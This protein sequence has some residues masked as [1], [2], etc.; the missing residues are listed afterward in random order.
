MSNLYIHIGHYKTGTT[1]LQ[2]FLAQNFEALNSLGINYIRDYRENAKHSLLAFSVLDDLNVD[3]LMY[4]YKSHDSYKDLW[5][6]LLIQIS[7]NTDIQN[8]LISSEEFIRISE[9]DGAVERLKTI[10]EMATKY[11]VSI[12]PIVYLREP[13]KH[14]ESWFNQLTK[15]NIYNPTVDYEISSFHK[16]LNIID[17]IHFDYKVALEPW[18]D[19]FGIENVVFKKYYGSSK[20]T[21]YIY[22]DFLSIF[23]CEL[24]DSF[25]IP[26]GNV[27]PRIDD[28]VMYLMGT[29]ARKGYHKA[30]IN[31]LLNRWNQFKPLSHSDKR[32][33]REMI[34]NARQSSQWLAEKTDGYLNFD[35][36]IS[37]ILDD[38]IKNEE[39]RELSAFLYSELLVTRQ[40]MRDLE[41]RL[42]EIELNHVDNKNL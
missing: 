5:T 35:G 16:S 24:D 32:N 1:A 9:F 30:S 10:Q 40:K 8:H 4:G 3:Y 15:M 2:V 22:N 39:L 26:K 21:E 18:V 27:N 37:A 33:T 41:N 12:K 31:H 6:K 19:V 14:L 36:N 29:L 23:S 34:D 25:K 38:S 17:R 13:L 7:E 11:N 20:P 28:T 42:N